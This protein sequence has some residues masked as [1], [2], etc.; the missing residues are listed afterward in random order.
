MSRASEVSA[1]GRPRHN[2]VSLNPLRR[3]SGLVFVEA[4]RRISAAERMGGSDRVGREQTWGS[5]GSGGAGGKACGRAGGRARACHGDNAA[6]RREGV[7][8]NIPTF[9]VWANFSLGCNGRV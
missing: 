7:K 1:G 9:V 4:E 8:L 5:R 3:A 6:G 2:V